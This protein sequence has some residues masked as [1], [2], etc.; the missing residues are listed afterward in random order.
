MPANEKAEITQR[1]SAWAYLYSPIGRLTL[2]A[3]S[4]G[5]TEIRFANN[6]T[7]LPST[8][9]PER[10]QG[11]AWLALASE[12]LNAYFDGRLQTFDLPL[13]LQGSDFQRR[14]WGQLQQVAH[15]TTASYGQLASA[16]GQPTAARAVGMANNKNPIPIVIPC[17]RI[18]GS[19]GLLTGFAGGLDAKRWLLAHEGVSFSDG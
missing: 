3:N 10:G 9:Q 2:L 8:R 11:K 5:L 1:V 12:Q 7:S 18:I 13:S 14:V 16:I 15:G 19:K 6:S 4:A 17:H